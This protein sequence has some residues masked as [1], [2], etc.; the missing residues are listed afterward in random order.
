[1]RASAEE[2]TLR[3]GYGSER[4]AYPSLPAQYC[5]QPIE[6]PIHRIAAIIIATSCATNCSKIISRIRFT[7]TPA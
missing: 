6:N 5:I 2:P 7:I 4:Y 1:M 3:I